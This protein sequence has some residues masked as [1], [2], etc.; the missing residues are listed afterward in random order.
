MGVAGE[1]L[2]KSAG[3][4]FD[5]STQTWWMP[6]EQALAGDRP[7]IDILFEAAKKYGTI[8]RVEPSVPREG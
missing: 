2:F 3:A 1:A 7:G 6:L 4:S 5:G 8:V